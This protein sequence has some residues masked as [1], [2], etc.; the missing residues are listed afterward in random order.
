MNHEDTPTQIVN[1]DE[2]KRKKK[3]PDKAVIKEPI[4]RFIIYGVLISVFFAL[5]GFLNIQF[6]YLSPL[7][8]VI[9]V[10]SWGIKNLF[11]KLNLKD[12]LQR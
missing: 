6:V 2:M 7:G 11:N 4:R 3:I 9:G 10:I 8:L 12:N 1:V 5:L